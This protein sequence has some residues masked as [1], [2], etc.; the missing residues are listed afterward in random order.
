M[1]L[2]WNKF[3]MSNDLLAVLHV[4]EIPVHPEYISPTIA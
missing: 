3:P 2:N 1:R 4:S